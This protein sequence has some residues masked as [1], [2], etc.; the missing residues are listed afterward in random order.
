MH[1]DILR[2]VMENLR[3]RQL[4]SWLT[5]LGIIIGITAIITLI[6]IGEGLNESIN[7]EL[8]AFGSQTII[9][10]PRINIGLSS[11]PTRT[12]ILTFNDV[13]T[14]KGTPGI[15]SSSLT[16]GVGGMMSLQYKD[17]NAS[18]RV[19]GIDTDTFQ[20]SVLSGL[21]QIE[22]G[23][24]LKPGDSHVVLLAHDP[25]YN[26]FKEKVNLG[27]QMKIGGED[28]RIVGILKSAG[29]AMSG[30]PIQILIPEEDARRLLGDTVGAR[31][32][33]AIWAKAAEGQSTGQ[34]AKAL[35]Q[36][37]M[38]KRKVKPDKLDF[39]ITTIESIQQQ[40]GM[41]TG[42]LTAFLGGI[43][44]IS[45]IVGAV[46]VANTMFMSV[47][48]RTR[49][50]GVLKAIGAR[51]NTIMEIFILE[52]SII[53]AI[54]G[55]IGL[56]LALLISVIINAFGAPSK[57]SPQLALFGFLFAVI[58]G[59]VS[60]FFPARRAARLQAVEALRYE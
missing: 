53:G 32:V 37:L 46:G 18:S 42:L 33:S 39:S 26:L 44:A 24:K 59:A 50:I 36:R 38:A 35:E 43:A 16:Y 27:Y 19:V 45:L 40:V 1:K 52:S 20:N 60:G 6:A 12:G 48:E 23:R 3:N 8:N 51:R 47:M 57:I 17:R 15:D 28:F 9:V 22:S 4:R 31:E 14:V 11:A 49:E 30:T 5:I 55:F 58:I 29:G 13:Q 10:T 54:G 2:Y 34:V 21:L 41:I 7:S 56:A 25:A